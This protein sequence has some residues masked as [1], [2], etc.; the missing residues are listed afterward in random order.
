MSGSGPDPGGFA[1]RRVS[2]RGVTGSGKT[3]FARRLGAFLGLPAIELDAL[4]WLPDWQQAAHDE[5][6]ARATAALDAFPNGWVC[7]GNY[8]G[9]LNDIVL[10]QADTVVW[11][12]LPWRVTFWRVLRRTLS[13]ARSG[14]LLWA[15]NRESLRQSFLHKD[16][17][18]LFSMTHHRAQARSFRA[19]VAGVAD[20]VRVYDL[21]SSREVEAFLSGVEAG[22]RAQSTT[23]KGAGA[24]S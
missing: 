8:S 15:N 22:V 24:T 20:R 5:F 4:F 16:S 9:R 1:G 13:R 7:D 21:R 10:A 12:H 17:L 18:L 2:V 3:T 23:R 6:R 14:E 19:G 11:L